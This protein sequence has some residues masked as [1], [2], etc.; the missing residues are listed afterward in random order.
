MVA[1]SRFVE[2]S[3]TGQ[4]FIGVSSAEAAPAENAQGTRGY[5]K[6]TALVGDNF[7]IVLL[8][9]DSM[10]V[11]I[12]GA[13]PFDIVLASGTDLD[14]RFIAR[15]IEYKLHAVSSGV[16]YQF[17]QCNW[18]NGGG[19]VNDRNTF[20]IYT[21]QTGNNST[22]NIVNVTAPA[23]ASRD[24]RATLGWATTPDE[25][26]GTV[27]SGTQAGSYTGT[28]TTSGAYGGQFDDIYTIQI[29][30]VESVGAV[31]P[32]GGNGYGGTAESG[33]IY[34]GVADDAY[35]ITVTA[36]AGAS[37][38][39]GTGS[40]PTF[41]VTDTPGSDQNSNAIEILYADRW[42]DVGDLGVRIKFS[43]GVFTTGDSFAIPATAVSGGGGSVESATYTFSSYQEDSSKAHSISP[44]TATAAGGGSQVGTRGVTV[45]FGDSGTLTAGDRFSIMCRGPQQTNSNITQLNFGNVTVS[46]HSP[47]KVVWFELISGANSMSTVKFSLQSN[48]TF[49]HHPP[50][51]DQDTFFRFGTCGA[52]NDALGAGSTANDQWEF[53]VD[54]TGAGRIIATDLSGSL[55]SY[56]NAIQNNLLV[57]SSADDAQALGNYQGAVV[58][59]FVWLA[60]QLGANETGANS[61]MNYRMFFDFST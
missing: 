9:T 22:N 29:A 10:K 18:R 14:P 30:D 40:V 21:G 52:G 60:I 49:S 46:T 3:V 58:S 53:P 50:D 24:C 39:A 33:G 32:N 19:G 7:D 17:A 38:G 55:P 41:A 1:V 27:S 47:V 51:G 56:L 37:P 45:S 25:A 8:D 15:D 61:T 11:D 48:G 31:T 6:A 36:T 16:D 59:D 12:N 5:S 20:I 28:V 2:F 43:D 44:I 34:T 13:G 42:Y 54:N 4:T 57:V 26:A 35:T 23:A